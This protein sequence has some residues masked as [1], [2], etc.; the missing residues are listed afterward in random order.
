MKQH[1]AG[2]PGETL[3]PEISLRDPSCGH[4]QA[5][6][7]AASADLRAVLTVFM[8]VTTALFGAGT[9]DINADAAN[10]G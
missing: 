5:R 6:I 3:R 7:G 10:R 8:L 1:P 2:H 9:A 4:L